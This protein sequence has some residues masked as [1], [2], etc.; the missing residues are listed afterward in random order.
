MSLDNVGANWARFIIEPAPGDPNYASSRVLYT[1]V[2]ACG[3]EEAGPE[4]VD[5]SITITG[6]VAGAIYIFV[7]V[8]LGPQG[9]RS[10]P[11]NVIIA[12]VPINVVDM[13]GL[14]LNSCGLADIWTLLQT[15]VSK[16]ELEASLQAVDGHVGVLA[17]SRDQLLDRIY[18]LEAEIAAI[19]GKL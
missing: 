6:L 16:R 9:A 8:A 15:K 17:A 2:T 10:N 19:R 18:R 1:Q 13:E 3:Y 4:Q 14:G 12:T 7:P 5:D 11:G